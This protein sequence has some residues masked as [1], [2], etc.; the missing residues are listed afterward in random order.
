VARRTCRFVG[1]VA[2]AAVVACGGADGSSRSELALWAEGAGPVGPGGVVLTARLTARGGDRAPASVQLVAGDVVVASLAQRSSVDDSADYSGTYAPASGL[3]GPLPLFARAALPRG[4][5][6]SP[7]VTLEVDTAAPSISALTVACVVERPDGACRRDEALHV[8]LR[9][10]ADTGAAA[11]TLDL[12]GHERAVELAGTG[13]LRTATI[14]LSGF[15]FG[16]F[17]ADVGVHATATDALGNR[18][19]A[20]R[21]TARVTRRLWDYATGGT[22]VTSPA[23]DFERSL[24]F[25]VAGGAG[26]QLRWIRGGC[27]PTAVP[28][29][30]PPCVRA[31]DVGGDVVVPQMAAGTVV[32]VAQQ[33]GRLMAVVNGGVANVSGNGCALNGPAVGPPALSQRKPQTAIVATSAAYAVD[34]GELCN[35]TASPSGEFVA[36][37]VVSQ[38]SHSY[39]VSRAPTG[40]ATLHAFGFSGTA[41]LLVTRWAIG[42]PV[43]AGVA[44][45]PILDRR[46]RILVS[47][48]DGKLYRVTDRGTSGSA[49]I[50][51]ANVGGAASAS[52]VILPDD[53]IVVAVGPRLHRISDAGTAMWPAPRDVGA[54]ITGLAAVVPD[55]SGVALYATTADGRLLALRGDG[56]DAWSTPA[57]LSDAALSAP[58]FT[59]ANYWPQLVVGG[60]D[61]HLR[62][63]VV[64]TWFDQTFPWPKAFH[65]ERN[66]SL[67]SF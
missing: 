57:Q 1:A 67:S 49:Q 29:P 63:V 50:L 26:G 24:V 54:E 43:G 4:T 10:S 18:T 19:A 31:V 65:D 7:P 48:G 39:I 36:T 35:G 58:G 2:A 47:S 5:V 9:V 46:A 32:W 28:Q 44:A 16:H 64:D 3:L 62:A 60:A 66:T 34:F 20:L 41:G 30:D 11:A 21:G 53:S 23:S 51:A 52:P 61:G 42:V 37:P 12:D 15:P 45:P 27:D 38:A 22:S 40:A 25:G 14:P 17:E 6:D 56:T 59:F 8:S 55:A 13:E 33:R